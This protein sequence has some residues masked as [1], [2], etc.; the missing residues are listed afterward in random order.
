MSRTSNT[1]ATI[2]I[3]VLKIAIELAV[4]AAAAGLIL[5]TVRQ[6][7]PFWL[8]L[9]CLYVVPFATTRRAPHP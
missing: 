6:G 8:V 2:V 4:K 3:G 1:P 5:A 7:G 9:A